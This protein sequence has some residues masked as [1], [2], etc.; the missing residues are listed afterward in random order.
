MILRT[1]TELNDLKAIDPQFFE[2]MI[3]IVIDRERRIVA[4]GAEM[5]SDMGIELYN[6]GS[7]EK[8]LYGAN[9]FWDGSLEWSSTL[10]IARNRSI[11]NGTYGRVI[12]D[13]DTIEDLTDIV[14]LWIYR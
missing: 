4:V 9:L 12:T 8:D 11:Q 2:D 7:D 6:D 3:K 14:N 10:N 5:H 13:E 1:K